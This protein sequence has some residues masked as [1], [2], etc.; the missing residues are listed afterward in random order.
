MPEVAVGDLEHIGSLSSGRAYEVAMSPLLDLIAVRQ[1]IYTQQE[2]EIMELSIAGL[3]HVDRLKEYT[4]TQFGISNMPDMKKIQDVMKGASIEFAPVKVARDE[5]TDA[6]VH[7]M[8]ISSGY[9]SEEQAIR[10]TH[11]EWSDE[12][13]LGELKKSGAD[14]VAKVDAEVALRSQNISTIIDA[15]E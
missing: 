11:P 1:V 6:Q 14:E 15:E 2:L 5:L 12:R 13:V 10:S 8:R 9:E 4:I 3:A 7:S